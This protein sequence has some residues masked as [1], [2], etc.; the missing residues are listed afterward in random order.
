VATI[1]SYLGKVYHADALALLR[2]MPGESVDA[3]VTDPMYGTSKN[4]PY[5]WGLDPA[6]GDPDKHWA[7]HQPSYQ[8]CLRVLKP[9]GVLAWAQGAK[10]CEHFPAWFGGHRVWTLTRY[11]RRGR[12]ATGHV[13]VVQTREQAPI[14]FPH[15]DSVVIF[16]TMFS[17]T[18]PDA[19]TVRDRKLHPCVKPVQEMA[20][21]IEALTQPGQIVLDCFCGLGSCLIAADQLHRQWIGCDRSRKYCQVARKRLDEI[22]QKTV[23]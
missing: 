16:D 4:C 20:F 6:R 15:R 10:F 19:M 2:T 22:K 23:A 8:E 13:W 5:D 21:M 9:G 3:I 14:E 11:R 12:N 7:Y 1:K 17:A 18:I